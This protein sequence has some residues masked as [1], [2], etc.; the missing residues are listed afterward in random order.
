MHF[1]TGKA[2]RG[3]KAV[4]VKAPLGR[5][6]VFYRQGSAYAPLFREAAAEYLK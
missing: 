2:C 3:G 5:P 6:P 4:T 1:W